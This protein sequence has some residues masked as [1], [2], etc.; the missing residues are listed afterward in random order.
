MTDAEEIE[1]AQRALMVQR[2]ASALELRRRLGPRSGLGTAAEIVGALA[3]PVEVSPPP[4][5]RCDA[6]LHGHE[7]ERGTCDACAGGGWRGQRAQEL[8]ERIPEPFR[9]ANL[10]APL[11]PP[12]ETSP[13]VIE[14]GREEARAW[15]SG[16]LPLLVIVAEVQAHDKRWYAQTGAGKTT[17]AAAVARALIE[18]GTS[19]AWVGA[20]H[21]D[22]THPDPER[23]RA[24]LRSLETS[25]AVVLDGLGKELGGASEEVAPGV[26]AQRKVWVGRWIQDMHEDTKR[27]AIVTIDVTSSALIGAYGNDAFR[28]LARSPRAQVIRLRRTSAIDCARF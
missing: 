14:E 21:L 10:E 26:A 13:V 2:E 17:L 25:P 20:R 19:V 5:C 11:I 23:A 24:A 6:R 4:R 12:G 9:W 27:R 15:V 3:G 18:G 7:R 16:S 8:L 22:P 28:R 1:E